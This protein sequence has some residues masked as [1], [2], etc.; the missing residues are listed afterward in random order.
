MKK[1]LIL[2]EPV[3]R[4]AHA[5]AAALRLKGAE[6]VL[7]QTPDFPSRSGE[8]ILFEADRGRITVRGPETDFGGDE[9]A[10]VWHRRPS[11]CLAGS[12]LHPADREFADLECNVFRRSLL[13][14]L[15]P[16]AF[17]VNPADAMTRAGRKPVQHRAALAA[18]LRM[19]D[20]LYSNDPAE[21]RAFLRRH[22]GRIVYKPF[23][24]QAWRNEE[25]WWTPYTSLRTEDDLV[26]DD[27]LRTTPGIFQELVP[28]AYE[29]RVTVMGR[30][31]LAAKILSQETE[32]GRL[33]WRKSY[34]ELRMEPFDLPRRLAERC[35]DLL[36]R[37][38]LVFGCF[39]F[40]VPPGG[41][42]VFLEVNEMGQFL[43]IER[44]A[45]IPL[46]DTFSEL[47]LQG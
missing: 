28:K 11:F 4:H 46:L 13:G 44:Y 1:I 32:N 18:G 45:D 43:F 29:L 24:G 31:A 21:I 33:D 3:D 2:T 34:G 40:I 38:G 37:L 20:T 30:H 16:D 35:V 26:A 27:L 19:P 5:V 9:W 39:D 8:S 25:T 41:D 42:P 23:R 7:W 22:G 14:V 47:L 12:P 10:S 17:W 15:A 6:P 36:E